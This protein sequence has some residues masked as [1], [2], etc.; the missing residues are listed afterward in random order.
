[1]RFIHT[2][3]VHWGMVPDSDRPWGKKREQAIR[4]T[5]QSI[6][7]EA[8][9]SKADLL[10]ISGDLFHRQPL[11]K[12]L[13]EVNYLF[14]TI[15]DTKVVI[16]AGN[17][18]RIRPNSAV[19]DF[20][21][22]PNVTFLTD[23]DLR[24]VYFPDINTEVYGFSYHSQEM[25]EM[26]PE[27]LN[28]ENNSHIQILMLH[29]GDSKHLPF[30]RNDLEDTPFS[31]IALGHIHR[32]AVLSENRIAYPG[33]PEPLDITET[34]PHGY[35]KGEIDDKTGVVTSLEFEEAS[36][37]KYI[38]LII[39][40]STSTTNSELSGLISDQIKSRGVQNIYRF[41]LKGMRDPD[42]DF[43]LDMLA[44]QWNIVEIIDETEPQYDFHKLLVDHPNDMIGFYI[45]SLMKENMDEMSPVEKKALYYGIHALLATKDERS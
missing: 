7:D 8:R 18:D 6:V 31:Y 22:A 9:E 36:Q 3:D 12:D 24:S 27:V 33:S 32:N 25:P 14:S 34:G 37:A 39:N 23:E 11:A 2:A 28:V 19:L 44:G 20:K 21:W 5:F 15:P 13:K 43:D 42:T 45:Q 41:R 35:L 38:S 1:M 29:G 16:I 10:L 17:H 4:L 30:D 40:V 26:R